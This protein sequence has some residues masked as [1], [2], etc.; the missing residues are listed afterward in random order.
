MRKLRFLLPTLVGF[1]TPLFFP[2]AAFASGSSG[3][4]IS[5]CISYSQPT[6]G[7]PTATPTNTPGTPGTPP[8]NGTPGT[9]G[10]PGKPPPGCK[11]IWAKYSGIAHLIAWCSGNG[12]SQNIK[13]FTTHKP[14]CHVGICA[15]VVPVPG[16]NGTPGTPG[17]PPIAKNPY[18]G[19]PTA[20]LAVFDSLDV[21][22]PT[23]AGLIPSP[24]PWTY[25]LYPTQVSIVPSSLPPNPHQLE[26]DR[27]SGQ[28]CSC[29][30]QRHKR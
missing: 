15:A 11:G 21:P 6:P 14:S 25:T 18:S 7:T 4:C 16:T 22:T 23:I 17:T 2:P 1:A 3:A 5:F 12:A 20:L 9:P 19:I 26:P 10:V 24:K 30:N 28:G 8:S 29:A 27:R 13:Y